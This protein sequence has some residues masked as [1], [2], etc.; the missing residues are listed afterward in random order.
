V[1]H[2]LPKPL[3]AKLARSPLSVVVCQVRH[4]RTVAASDPKRA[5]SIHEAVKSSYPVLEEQSGQELTIA[6]GPAGVQ[7]VPGAAQR[8]WKLRSVDQAWNAVIMPEFFSLETTR[9]ND[10]P[11]FRER[12]E[13]LAQAVATA[14]GP[15]LEQRIGLRYINRITHPDIAGPTDWSGW[16]DESFLG[17]IAHKRLGPTVTLSQQV[18]QLEMSDGRS[19]TLRHGALRDQEARGAWTYLIDQD[20]FM[21]HGR[22][23]AVPDIL[24]AI[25]QLHTLSLQV[26]QQ[27]ITPSL[28]TF[29]KG[30]E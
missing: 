14:V 7:T 25:E 1:A 20:C 8:G 16:I 29:L 11:D 22:P 3:T 15:S 24:D 26:F 10:W 12:L 6:A 19:V 18:L 2:A 28:Y 30:D 13:D 17:P 21:Q 23:F 9:Y 5:V 27:T 4:E